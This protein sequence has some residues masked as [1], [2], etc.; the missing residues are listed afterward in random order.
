[1]SQTH[2]SELE[3]CAHNTTKFVSPQDE[4]VFCCLPRYLSQQPSLIL[5]L[6]SSVL[7]NWLTEVVTCHRD[8]PY[9]GTA[10]VALKRW[11]RLSTSKCNFGKLKR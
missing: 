2:L 1:M 10:S 3:I 5:P 9:V 4:A 8:T 7:Y 11:R 6:A